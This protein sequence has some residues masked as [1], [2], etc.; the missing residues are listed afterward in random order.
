MLSDPCI[1]VT[2]DFC[3][4]DEEVPLT[5]CARGSYDE[6]NVNIT[7]LTWGWEAEGDVHKCPDCVEKGK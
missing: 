7:L 2:C 5:A 4:W 6:R 3:G 1:F